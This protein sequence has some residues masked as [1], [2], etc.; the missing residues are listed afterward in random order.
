MTKTILVTGGCGFI[1]SHTIVLL[2]ENGY[3]VVVV[4]NLSNSIP[5]SLDRVQ[6]IVGLDDDERK[7]RLVFHEVDVRDEPAF[8]KVFESSP[9]FD[10]C[11]HFAAL[12]VNHCTYTHD[13]VIM[14]VTRCFQPSIHSIYNLSRLW[15]K[16]PESPSNTTRT[17]LVELLSFYDCW[18]SLIAIPFASLPRPLFTVL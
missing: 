3:N 10:A 1:G 12:K 16:A 11:I 8:R 7:K 18:T 13:S 14:E 9:S 17:T 6:K 4:D 15:E 5:V 2:L